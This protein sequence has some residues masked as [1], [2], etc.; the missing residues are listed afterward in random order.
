MTEA[1]IVLGRFD[2]AFAGVEQRYAELRSS[3]ERVCLIGELVAELPAPD[4]VLQRLLCE[5]VARAADLEYAIFG[6]ADIVDDYWPEDEYPD[7]EEQEGTR[8]GKTGI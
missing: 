3:I 2:C 8:R 4:P 7:P 6:N 5:A 1:A